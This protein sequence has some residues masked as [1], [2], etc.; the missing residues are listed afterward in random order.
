MRLAAV[1]VAALIAAVLA[2]TAEP[3][4][5]C[6]CAVLDPRDTLAHA[7]GAFIGVLVERGKETNGIVTLVFRVE[8]RIKGALGET[9]S[10]RTASNGAACGIEAR[11]GSRIGLFLERAGEE[12]RSSLCAEIEPARLREAAQPLPAVDG[13]GP[14]AL[15]VGGQFGP[16]RT[17]ALD[18]NGRTLAYGAG[19]GHVV[20]V[21]ICRGG[22][23]LTEIASSNS[24]FELVIRR[25]RSLRVVRR[26][27]LTLPRQRVPTGLL[28]TNGS[29]S[30]LVIFARWREGD[31]PF[32]SALFRLEGRRLQTIWQGTASYAS[33]TPTL[34]Y[35]TVGMTA[36]RLVSIDVRSGRV[37][38]L[39]AVPADSELVPDSTGT[40]L[41]GV[42]GRLAERSR[43][44]LVDLRGRASKVRTAP[45]A[46]AEVYGTVAWL[47]GARFV[48]LPWYGRD[49]ARVLDLS[50]R[51]RA[52]FRW[53]AGSASVAGS[54]V[55][56]VDYQG[57]LFAARLPGGPMRV[58]RR[59]PG[60][61][62]VIVST[63]R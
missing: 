57:T 55:F 8:E 50:L 33:L 62:D 49:M 47:H 35:A 13:R 26:Q 51:T 3:A 46:A 45:L 14:V 43:I 11:V 32:G 2:V 58:V 54:Q 21:S 52:S 41:A 27:R 1:S 30:K 63:A 59:L 31:S 61:P 40:F 12:W 23:R 16:A 25:T 37:V 9:V 4:R 15:I 44:V 22:D 56:G 34:A 17:L 38:R 6:S 28:C 60:R 24:T 18:A 7:D 20:L 29:G 19:S 39:G 42:A 53:L 5:A 48:F 36:D 10:V